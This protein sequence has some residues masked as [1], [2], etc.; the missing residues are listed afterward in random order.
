MKKDLAV[1]KGSFI[2][3]MNS[4]SQEFHYVSPDIFFKIV[5]IYAV[6]FPGSSLWDLFSSDCDR[7]YKAWNVA[8]RMAWNLP[9][10]THRYLVEP[11]SQSLHLKVMMASRYVNLVKS[12]SSSPKYVVRVLTAVCQDDLR[13]VMGRTLWKL[14]IECTCEANSLMPSGIKKS[15]QYF[16]LPCGEEWRV[17][18]FMELSNPDVLI[19]GFSPEEVQDMKN[20]LC[21]S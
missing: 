10:T 2:G 21:T 20:F 17:P 11:I 19:P 12:L 16:P 9:F 5:N 8:V 7:L 3:K 18:A 4:L 1:K 14:A 15:L 13:T 6:S